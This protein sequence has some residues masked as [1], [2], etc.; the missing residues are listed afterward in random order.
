MRLLRL[1]FPLVLLIMVAACFGRV[2]EI[3]VP[4][5]YSGA[6]HIE[7]SVSAGTGFSSRPVSVDMSGKGFAGECPATGLYPK[8]KVTRGGE[9]VTPSSVQWLSTGDGI[10]V[11]L[12]F[13]VH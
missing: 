13:T 3:E 1:L 5:G 10:K 2:F 12:N 8:V 7:C 6:V 9:V 4:R 11:G